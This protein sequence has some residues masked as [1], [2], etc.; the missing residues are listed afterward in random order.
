VFGN[1]A[2]GWKLGAALALI[3]A[4]GVMASKRGDPINPSLWRCLSDPPHW[5]GKHLWLPTADVVAV[6]DADYDLV[7]GDIRMRVAGRPPSASSSRVTLTA[8]FHADGPFLEQL[9]VRPI[10]SGSPHRRLM[11][12][13]SVLVVLGV[14]ANFARHFLFRPEVLQVGP[15]GD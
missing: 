10:P 13:V 8:V 5:N 2:Y 11:E 4:M 9:E 15:R 1:K 6:R 14:L 7:S 3:A 12:V